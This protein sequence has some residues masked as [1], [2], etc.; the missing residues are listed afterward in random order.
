MHVLLRIGEAEL[1]RRDRELGLRCGDSKIAGDGERDPGAIAGPFDH[2]DRRDFE[3][4]K[5][6]ERGADTLAQP[7]AR[8]RI[9]KK[10]AEIGQIDARTEGAAGSG[11]DQEPGVGSRDL[12]QPVGDLV[13]AFAGD[14]IARLGP[15]ERETDD[16][17]F[18]T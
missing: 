1:G 10:A 12:G 17:T 4:A 3:R 6:I 16:F 9:A 14:C 11:D 7:R 8:L 2:R 13:P 5:P 18:T 15:I